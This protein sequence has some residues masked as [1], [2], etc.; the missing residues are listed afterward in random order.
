MN[1]WALIGLGLSVIFG[2]AR[3][4]FPAVPTKIANAGIIGGI[5]LLFLGILMP[6][7]QLS[8]AAILLFLV[9]CLCF[10]GAAHIVFR[11]A[12][13]ASA[14]TRPQNMPDVD[15]EMAMTEALADPRYS[16]E[17]KAV[18]E[19]QRDVLPFK[20]EYRTS[21]G[22]VSLDQMKSPE[23]VAFFNQRLRESGK[24]WQIGPD[25]IDSTFGNV[26]LDT[27]MNGPF[28]AGVKIKGGGGNTFDQTDIHGAQIGV[29][30]EATKENKF[31]NTRIST[32]TELP[33]K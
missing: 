7:Y 23:A 1:G 3:W 18:I 29:D 10:G 16:P 28:T 33:K 4:R 22:S 11:G 15:L 26:M 14:Q 12:D 2:F 6:N 9:G 27:S 30:L 19:R 31:S 21:H 8:P 17:T 5:I 32:P 20:R 25:N 24:N 13:T